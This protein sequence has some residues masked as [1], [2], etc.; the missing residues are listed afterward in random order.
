VCC[1]RLCVCDCVITRTAITGLSGRAA[2][3]LNYRLRFFG[4]G[5]LRYAELEVRRGEGGG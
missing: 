1:V 4:I 2:P 5:L 3:P